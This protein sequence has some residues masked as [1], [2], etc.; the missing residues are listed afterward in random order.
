LILLQVLP[1]EIMSQNVYKENVEF[2]KLSLTTL[3]LLLLLCN[4]QSSVWKFIGQYDYPKLD[5][6]IKLNP[7]TLY[8]GTLAIDLLK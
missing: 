7:E 6:P 5:C 1:P 4:M 3:L 8:I 2:L